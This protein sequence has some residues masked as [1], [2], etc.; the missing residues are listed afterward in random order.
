MRLFLVSHDPHLTEKEGST[1][2]IGYRCLDSYRTHCHKPFTSK[3]RP[4]E[5]QHFQVIASF[6][7]LPSR[8]PH[9][10]SIFPRFQR[11]TH[12]KHHTRS[13]SEQPR[14]P[15]V[16]TTSGTDSLPGDRDR[17]ASFIIAA[18]ATWNR[19]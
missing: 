9:P 19:G 18:S 8:K 6:S 3:P 5:E 2:I 11:T 15:A 10:F 12:L 4:C 13:D 14:P 16:R 17:D 1:S 7:S